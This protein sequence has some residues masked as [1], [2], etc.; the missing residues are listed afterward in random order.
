MA[1]CEKSFEQSSRS[2]LKGIVYAS[3]VVF[4]FAAFVLVSRS[5]LSTSLHLADIAALRF[6][7]GAMLLLPFLRIGQVKKFHA[8]EMLLLA[9][10][11]GLGFAL[12]AYAGFALAPASHGGVL[13]HGTL[14]LT[15]YLLIAAFGADGWSPKGRRAGLGLIAI[16]VI[17]ILWEGNAATT[18]EILLGDLCLIAA[19]FSWSG[20]GLYAKKLGIPA[21]QAASVVSIWS[22]VAFLPFYLFF[23]DKMLLQ[24]DWRDL[25]IQAGFQG[26]LIGAGSIFIYT[27]ATSLLGP[28][29]VSTFT[30]AVPCL[31]LTGGLLF[32]GERP[33]STAIVGASLVTAGMVVAL[34]K[35][36][37]PVSKQ[38][39]S[40]VSERITP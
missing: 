39:N 37:G 29:K 12:L 13:I 15:T 35:K 1:E 22:A 32:L 25:V 20:Y 31:T 14:A 7:I 17:G 34:R 6:G 8:V 26:V 18:P 36:R 16:G 9:A 11:G 28:E 40:I 10:L 21:V 33:S 27:R 2:Q 3:L 4:L 38:T 5:G 24:A 30:A 23:A 19:S